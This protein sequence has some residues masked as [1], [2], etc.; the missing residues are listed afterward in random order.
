M[1]TSLRNKVARFRKNELRPVTPPAIGVM[2]RLL[3]S[4]RGASQRA[5]EL[6][7]THDKPRML[8][9]AEAADHLGLSVAYLMKLRVQG[10]GPV[11]VK[12]GSTRVTYDPADLASWIESNKR[13]ST[14][15]QGAAA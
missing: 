10:G 7:L 13:R 6:H 2:S 9:T 11:F 3:L 1:V 8:S 15:D 5:E 4:M 14:S 12:A